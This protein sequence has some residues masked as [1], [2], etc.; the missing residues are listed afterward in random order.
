LFGEATRIVI[1]YPSP[2]VTMAAE[3]LPPLSALNL[4][5]T[6]LPPS[7]IS[8]KS[9]RHGRARGASFANKAARPS[10]RRGYSIQEDRETTVS[11]AIAFALKRA[12]PDEDGSGSEDEHLTANADGWVDLDDLVSFK[13][14]EPQIQRFPLTKIVVQLEHSHI[15]SRN[16]SLTDVQITM[17]AAVGKARL[18]LRQQPNTDDEDPAS[19][20]IRRIALPTTAEQD[21]KTPAGSDA[22]DLTSESTDLPEFVAFETS[23]ARYPLI[24]AAG[25]IKRAGGQDKLSLMPVQV[26]E[27]G[28]DTTLGS[29]AEVSIFI[30]LRAAMAAA[31]KIEWQ[32]TSAGSITTAGD[33]AGS[34]PT[35]LWSKVVGRRQD[36]G[37]LFEDG[38]VKK[39][40]PVG[41][42][43]KGAKGK[44]E[45]GGVKRS[46]RK[47]V[48]G[49]AE[50][51]SSDE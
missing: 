1:K 6:V 10:H 31:P 20:Q 11:K 44:K 22:E 15:K 33:A 42:R 45:K 17:A 24:L 34:L 30:N 38:Q 19:Y 49:R 41:L 29:D 21:S 39:E 2:P 3:V 43:G 35:S 48:R 26:A 36:I 47:N 51:S 18:A 27:H 5:P 7:P 40:V 13:G 46:M 4:G 23:Y 14:I 32:R 28:K 9:P 25:S 16:I 12:I 37:V 8:Q 50:E